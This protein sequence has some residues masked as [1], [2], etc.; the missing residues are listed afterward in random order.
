MR[1][2]G[3]LV[4]AEG[5]WRTSSSAAASVPRQV[6]RLVDV[7]VDTLQE[8]VQR[9]LTLVAAARAD[10]SFAELLLAARMVFDPPPRDG[11]LLD[12][13]DCALQAGLLEERGNSY[14]FEHP[15][16]QAALYQQLTRPRQAR[17]HAALAH[18][19]KQTRPN[20]VEVLA[21]HFSRS[22]DHELAVYYLERAADRA[23]ATGA[24]SAAADHQRE[25]TAQLDERGDLPNSA[26]VRQKLATVLA[27]M[28][29]HDRA[30]L[31]LQQAAQLYE[32]T[33]DTQELQRVQARLQR[34]T[35]LLAG[36]KSETNGHRRSFV[37]PIVTRPRPRFPARIESQSTDEQPA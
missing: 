11:E 6:Q 20:E 19:I 15:L 7:R 32:R 22:H 34:I 17:L 23:R 5:S 3:E 16:V 12:T 36:R 33:G 4:L 10:L 37:T 29:E 9:V 28:A 35:P 2:R 31:T 14:G 8:D 13:L 1:G 26:R 30:L 27:D 21:Y 24:N 25:L 18:A